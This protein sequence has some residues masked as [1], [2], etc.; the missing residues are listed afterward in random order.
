ML[1]LFALA[2]TTP[3]STGPARHE[4]T[5]AQHRT[6]TSSA[7]DVQEAFADPNLQ[8]VV[9]LGAPGA[10]KSTAL[11]RLAHQQAQAAIEDPAAPLPIY[12]RLTPERF[13]QERIYAADVRLAG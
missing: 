6:I 4:L 8:R 1:A 5:L 11:Q 12:V 10:G 13:I 7:D 2:P 9:V 3:L